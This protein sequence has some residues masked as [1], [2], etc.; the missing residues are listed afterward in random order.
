[1]S[2]AGELFDRARAT[3]AARGFD[4][5]AQTKIALFLGAAKSINA[6]LLGACELLPSTGIAYPFMH[7]Q[8]FRESEF[9][10]LLARATSWSTNPQIYAQSSSF[11]APLWSEYWQIQGVLGTVVDARAAYRGLAY[12][13]ALLARIR[14]APVIPESADEIDP[15][16]AAIRRIEQENGRMIQVQI[17]LLKETRVEMP[18]E[19]REQIVETAQ[20]VVDAQFERFLA[21]LAQP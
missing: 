3:I 18:K 13:H 21:W 20:Q 6:A 1:V 16:V 17:R 12:G 9:A 19:E 4:A 14:L 11:I 15:F 2:A 8:F 10:T 7:G 5:D